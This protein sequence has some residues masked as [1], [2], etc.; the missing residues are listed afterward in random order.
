MNS[1]VDTIELLG[2][3]EQIDLQR[4]RNRLTVLAEQVLRQSLQDV[5]LG[6]DETEAIQTSGDILHHWRRFTYE[7]G[8]TLGSADC[9][10]PLLLTPAHPC[11]TRTRLLRSSPTPHAS[12][13]TS[14]SL[15]R[16]G[17]FDFAVFRDFT[18]SVESIPA[19]RRSGTLQELL[20]QLVE[21]GAVSGVVHPRATLW[22]LGSLSRAGQRRAPVR[23][24]C[25]PHVALILFSQQCCASGR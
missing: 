23:S 19:Q 20:A 7:R 13:D 25:S 6:Y 9:D 21:V 10:N 15:S 17:L 3:F 22:R 11:R 8:P 18:N 4:Y 16:D 1:A 14:D 2:G 12:G 24:G 5:L